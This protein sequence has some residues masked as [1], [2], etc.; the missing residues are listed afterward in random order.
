MFKIDPRICE[1]LLF[2]KTKKL[3]GY[4]INMGAYVHSFLLEYNPNKT[5]LDRFGGVNGEI[6][7]AISNHLNATAN[8]KFYLSMGFIDDEDAFQSFLKD[9]HL[10]VLD[11]AM[12]MNLLR[13]MWKKQTYPH[14]S[15][16][17]CMVSLKDHVTLLEKITLVFPD[18]TWFTIGEHRKYNTLISTK[19]YF[20]TFRNFSDHLHRLDIRP[21]VTL[22]AKPVL[23][24][25]RVSTNV[26]KHTRFQTQ[27]TRLD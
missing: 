23:R 2:D 27:S 11:F 5:G 6:T 17:F 19:L 24:W 25:I 4:T 21:E 9:L 14:E 20:I 18:E 7:R 8:V 10:G 3:N 12:N 15:S 22:Q 13:R 1:N 16:G 26:P